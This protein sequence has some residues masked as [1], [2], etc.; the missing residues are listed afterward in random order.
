[1]KLQAAKRRKQQRRAYR[2][3]HSATERKFRVLIVDEN[4]ICR[5]GLRDLLSENGRFEIVAEADHGETA[6]NVILEK[7][8]DVAV[9]DVSL[10]GISGL[11]VA[12]RLK[13]K[14]CPTNLV[15]F[16]LQNDEKLFNE[17]ISLGI[18]GYVLKRNRANEIVDCIAAVAR[19]AAYV[20]PLMT[21]FLLRRRSRT[22]SLRRRQPGLG[23][24]TAAER[25]ILKRVAQ[26]QTSR[27]IAAE[28]G[29]SPRT[30]D[31]HRAHICER[32][33]LSGPNRLLQFAFEH[34]DALSHLD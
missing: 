22:D 12:A 25:C 3:T 18:R 10:P 5:R 32:L 6:L 16:T 30:V 13:A 27:E 31:S 7:K 28:C 24:L 23:N 34:R 15:I 19:G 14:G 1:M 33:G 21:D 20:S 9:L 11:E 26:G 8:P 4:P 2:T 17:A 29:I